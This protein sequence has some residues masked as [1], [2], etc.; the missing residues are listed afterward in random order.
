MFSETIAYN[1][2]DNSGEKILLPFDGECPIC[3][4]AISIHCLHAVLYE[5]EYN[6]FCAALCRCPGCK[7]IYLNKYLYDERFNSAN[8]LISSEPN[9]FVE[10]F[11]D[12]KINDISP[13][14]VKIYNQALNAEA[15]GLDQ[16]AGIGYRKA[17]EFLIKDFIISENSDNAEAIKKMPL[18]K[19]INEYIDDPR[20]RKTAIKSAW[21]GNDEAHYFKVYIDKDVQDLKK[22]IEATIAFIVIYIIEKESDEIMPS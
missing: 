3:K 11:F 22:L 10:K 19:C 2:I 6:N 13:S 18:S 5:K 4:R 14:F 1:L 7:E 17:L 21:L 9:R 8:A 20:I 15:I 12:E 16:I